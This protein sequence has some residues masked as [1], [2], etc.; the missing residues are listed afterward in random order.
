MLQRNLSPEGGVEMG[1]KV[2]NNLKRTNYLCK[3]L[4][5][6][7]KFKYFFSTGNFL[8]FLP[9]SLIKRKDAC[10]LATRQTPLQRSIQGRHQ[11]WREELVLPPLIRQPRFQDAPAGSP[12]PDSDHEVASDQPRCMHVCTLPRYQG[13]EKQRIGS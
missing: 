2:K 9:A 7:I 5:T 11:Q 3:T 12:S 1:E 13:Y 6:L 4:M 10:S 8:I